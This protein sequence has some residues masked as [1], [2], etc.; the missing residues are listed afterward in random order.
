MSNKDEN[1]STEKSTGQKKVAGLT[2]SA[3]ITDF[4]QSLGDSSEYQILQDR[5]SPLIL[6]SIFGDLDDF[7]RQTARN[8]LLD[9]SKQV[10]FLVSTSQGGQP[11]ID[12]V[13]TKD[14]SLQQFYIAA[15]RPDDR[16]NE[17]LPSNKDCILVNYNQSK[18]YS[19][20]H[21][22]EVAF[23]RSCLYQ[24]ILFF[25]TNTIT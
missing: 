5:E 3:A 22:M 7:N 13:T 17:V 14:K 8:I 19:T 12:A 10:I 15:H 11:L 6:D 24:I 9:M 4:V 18:A 21:K 1:Q 16:E 25:T 23:N 20:I 2:I